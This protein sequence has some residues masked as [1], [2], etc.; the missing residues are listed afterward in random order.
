MLSALATIGVA[1]AGVGATATDAPAAPGDAIVVDFTGGPDEQGALTALDLRSGRQRPVSTNVRSAQAGRASLL[2]PTAM[3]VAPNGDVLVADTYGLGGEPAIFRIDPTTGRKV[4]FSSNALSERRGGRR[5]LAA[6]TGLAL[7]PAGDLLVTSASRSRSAVVR[8]DATTRKHS[9]VTTNA[10]SRARGGAAALATPVAIAVAGRRIAVATDPTFSRGDRARVVLVDG[11]SGRQ[12]VLTTN[13][14]SRGAGGGAHLAEPQSVAVGADRELLVGDRGAVVRVDAAGRQR[15]LTRDT[16]DNDG[17]RDFSANV[18]GVVRRVDGSV[19]A[20]TSELASD[21]MFLEQVGSLVSIDPGTGRQTV[22]S[23]NELSASRGGEELLLDPAALALDRN[24]EALIADQ[25]STEEYGPGLVARVDPLTGRQATLT[26]N[27]TAGIRTGE[28]GFSLPEGVAMERGGTLLVAERFGFA[29]DG[30]ILR[31]DPRTGRQ[32]VLASNAVANREGTPRL[33]LRPRALA[34]ARYGIAFVTVDT[35][36]I[37]VD[38]GSGRQAMV[39][40]NA[41]S[42]ERGGASLLRRPSGIAIDRDGT[43]LVTDSDAFGGGGGV[44]RVD[45][46]TGRQRPLSSNRISRR[47]GGQRPFVEPNGLAISR[48]GRLFVTDRLSRSGALVEVD[49]GSGRARLFSTNRRSRR[50]RGKTAFRNPR[51]V[52]FAPGGGLLVSDLGVGGSFIG[53]AGGRVVRVDGRSGRQGRVYTNRTSRRRGGPAL[54]AEPAG[55]VI[56]R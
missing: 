10:R 43:L 33:L 6:P 41:L 29:G 13:R 3:T 54:F 23:T 2:E 21:G 26:S 34:L 39:S 36:V 53:A 5:G 42:R 30:S 1:L 7:T 40:S 47:A 50:L 18:T 16:R 52:A 48:G 15:L 56:E 17:G 35:A 37:T 8:I 25:A 14:I 49:P 55:L 27:A 28:Q 22:I 51:G 46:R 45:P 24:G 32:T 11:R 44:I 19:L 20:V 9:F 4:V 12:R 31:V 38:P